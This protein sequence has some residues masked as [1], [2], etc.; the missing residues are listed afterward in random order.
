MQFLQWALPRLSLRWA[1]FRK[2]RRQVCKRIQRRIRTIGLAD[3]N[4]YRKLLQTD[5]EEWQVLDELCRI[6]ISRFFRDR[7]VFDC[8]GSHVLPELARDRIAAG[9]AV[10]RVWSAG[11][12]SGE[13]PYS[14]ALL[15]DFQLKPEF[16]DLRFTVTAT[17]SDAGLLQRADE[18]CY[19]RGCLKELPD[20]W[21]KA[22][23]EEVGVAYCLQSDCKRSVQFLHQDLRREFPDGP[24]T[25]ILC[26]NFVFTY[27]DESLQRYMC[28]ELIDALVPGGAL[29]IGR[30]ETLPE[31]RGALNV[32]SEPCRVYRRSAH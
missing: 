13:E 25:L 3:T 30:K 27:F 22:A 18:A 4:A 19:P 10:L 23:F 5:K 14:L 7:E 11:C 29:V 17:D 32:W 20:E 28:G 12:G 2:V 26:R 24:F 6:T 9:D 15:W 21:F 31:N 1:G 8:L 16:P